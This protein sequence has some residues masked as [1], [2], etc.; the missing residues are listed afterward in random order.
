MP[1][2]IRHYIRQVLLGF[3]L[4]AMFVAGLIALDVAGLRHLVLGSRSGWLAGGLLWLFNGLVFAGAQFAVSILL[5]SDQG[6]DG[7]SGRR[8][9]PG[10]APQPQPV[11]VPVAAVRRH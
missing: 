3:G 6:T 2:L 4:S 9:R 11:A 7:G 5:M 1:T 10:A 8:L